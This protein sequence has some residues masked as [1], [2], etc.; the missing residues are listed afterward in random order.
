MFLVSC[1]NEIE[2]ITNC[3]KSNFFDIFIIDKK[4]P[5]FVKYKMFLKIVLV[6]YLNQK[7]L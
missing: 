1:I 4:K 6:D 7:T 3:S 5:Y 2:I